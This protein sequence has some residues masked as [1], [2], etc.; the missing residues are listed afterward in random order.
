LP[1]LLRSSVKTVAFQT[2]AAGL[3]SHVTKAW[4]SALG[5]CSTAQESTR[6]HVCP[7]VC[8]SWL[9]IQK[10]A[11]SYEAGNGQLRTSLEE[12][13]GS[14]SGGHQATANTFEMLDEMLSF[15]HGC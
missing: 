10:P 4:G 8:S 15:C 1:L 13:K 2:P 14:I 11:Y 5:S 7:F 9:E 6:A 12:K 3:D